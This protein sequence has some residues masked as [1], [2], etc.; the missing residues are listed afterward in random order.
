[1]TQTG[2]PTISLI[3]LDDYIP[4]EFHGEEQLSKLFE[5]KL[6]VRSKNDIDE[7]TQ[8]MLGK[9][10]T[11]KILSYDD[12]KTP[13]YFNGVIVKIN[14][15][16]Y[17]A[18][19]NNKRYIYEFVL[20]PDFYL[21]KLHK[22][23]RVFQNKNIIDIIKDVLSDYETMEY[24]IENKEDYP[25]LE[26][27]VQYQETDFDFIARLLED[28]GLF[29]Y[30]EHSENKNV[31]IIAD[32][33]DYPEISA[34]T[35][36][37]L[38]RRPEQAYSFGIETLFEQTN[39]VI[40]AYE[41]TDFDE[42][43]PKTNLKASSGSQDKKPYFEYPGN[44]VEKSEGDK[45]AKL[46]LETYQ[47]NQS[48][49]AG[50]SRDAHMKPGYISSFEGHAD[51]RVNQRFVMHQV[52][53]RYENSEYQNTFDAYPSDVV[54][55]PPL[56]TSIPK[57]YGYQTAIVV[58]QQEDEIYTD[59]QGRI[60]VRFH[61]DL[62]ENINDEDR[63]CWI[64]V[65]QPWA[66]KNFGFLYLPRVGQEVVVSFLDGNPN[67]PMVIGSVYNQDHPPPLK[68]PDKKNVSVIQS[69]STKAGEPANLLSMDDSVDEELF[70]IYAAKDCTLDVNNKL[71]T[72]VQ[73]DEDRDNKTNYSQVVADDYTLETTK[74][75]INLTAGGGINITA[76]GTLAIKASAMTIDV[77]SLT[78][79]ASASVSI[80]SKGSLDLNGAITNL[81]SKSTVTINGSA[82]VM[83]N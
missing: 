71:S 80:D 3:S 43:K 7:N 32:N 33:N 23:S 31:L 22:T 34:K 17:Q 54:Y 39:M 65:A 36:V 56:R 72:T 66:G 64:R 5:Y 6:L 67:R 77:T 58:G 26:Y 68:L 11:V 50:K 25:K 51:N 63:T 57:I 19:Q 13:C 82:M 24:K 75:D 4:L 35:P 69:R 61:W 48:Q 20:N 55:H 49:I 21:T 15:N 78:I 1:M 10:A 9:K 16:F 70:A 37:L 79:N 62:D 8:Q 47:M 83:I 42:S 40:D 30:F 53:H 46:R 38:N 74:G 29:Y 45:K 28:N 60:K 14:I 41:I 27:C 44:Y 76:G 81:I 12:N 2:S 18:E 52:T 59:D 73:N